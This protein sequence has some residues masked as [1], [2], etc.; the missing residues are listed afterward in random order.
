MQLRPYQRQLEA[1]VYAAWNSRSTP[2]NAM[3]VAATGSG[4]TVLFSK[5]LRDFNGF[6]IAIA[7]RQEL[8]SQMSITLARNR[9][10]HRV[11]APDNVRRMIVSMQIAETGTS[12]FDPNA[13]CA[14]AGVDTLIGRPGEPWMRQNGLMVQDE[15]HHVL[16]ENKWGKAAAMLPNS[17]GLLPTATPCRADGKGLGR[18]TDGLADFLILA[19]EM[20]DIIDMGYLTDYRVVLAESDVHLGADD[21]SAA[22][23]DFNQSKLRDAHHKSKKIVGDVVGAY[24]AY[25]RGKLGITFAVDVEEATKLAAG[26]RAAGVAAEVVSAKTPDQLRAAIIRRFKNREILQL[27]N[28]D[29]FGEGFDLPALEVVSFARHTAS[30]ALY[31]Q[32]FGRALR[33]MIEAQL[34]AR[35]DSFT[36]EERRAAIAASVKPRAIII[37]HVGNIMRHLG[38]PDAR[39]RAGKWTLDRRERGSRGANDAPPLKQCLNKDANDTGLPCAQPYEAFLTKCPHCGYKPAPA[40]RSG[41][42]HVEG[43]MFELDDEALARLRGDIFNNLEAPLY[44]PGGNPTILASLHARRREKQDAVYALKNAVAWWAGLMNSKGVSDAEAYRRFYYKFGTDVAT[45][46]TYDR[47]QA[48]DLYARVAA[49]LAKDNIDARVNAGVHLTN[50]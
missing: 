4:K 14:V 11:I 5:F 43:D 6:S 50:H 44:A 10:R 27:V 33:L 34:A 28:V 23:G 2:T 48:A 39:W 1:D 22:T 29:L 35:W 32:Q 3:A 20:R 42:E 18:E 49:E 45:M 25:A 46:Q 26:Y 7:H 16:R 21:I 30:F 38:P 31:S 9:V 8:V 19:P 17:Y 15:A 41:P 13:K 24:L 40:V 37:D 36:N 47:A 12:Y